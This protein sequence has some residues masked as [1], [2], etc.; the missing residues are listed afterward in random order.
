[1]SEA[2]DRSSA[3]VA[4]VRRI[5]AG[6][7]AAE[8][9]LVAAFDRTVRLW[10][11][12]RIQDADGQAEVFQRVLWTALQKLREGGLDDPRAL[13]GWLRSLTC[14]QVKMYL[15]RGD[16]ARFSPL[17]EEGLSP[18][19]DP[20]RDLLRRE[21]G[22]LVR[23]LLASLRHPRDREV[24]YRVYFQ[25]ADKQVICEEMGLGRDQLNRVVSR[26]RE[27]FRTL[28]EGRRGDNLL[29]FRQKSEK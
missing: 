12:R 15:T 10:I 7:A 28:V 3:H 11:R 14:N 21:Q 26:A 19:P 24:L 16:H 13:P 23:E 18:R 8:A 27:R 9:E 17:E 20:L 6:D 22:A 1:M 29:P 5:E 25:G 2:L 4:L